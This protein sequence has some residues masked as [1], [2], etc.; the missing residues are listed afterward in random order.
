MKMVL[1][2]CDMLTWSKRISAIMYYR[3]LSVRYALKVLG[4]SREVV[5]NQD[6][7]PDFVVGSTY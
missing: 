2:S 1:K 5:S 4:M 6:A 3:P 7:S